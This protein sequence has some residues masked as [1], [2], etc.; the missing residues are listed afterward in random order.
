MV[1]ALPPPPVLLVLVL[2][3]SGVEGLH[4]DCSR[5]SQINLTRTDNKTIYEA[6]TATSDTIPT[7]INTTLYVIPE[8]DFHG[9]TLQTRNEKGQYEV[10]IPTQGKCYSDTKWNELKVTLKIVQQVKG[11]TFQV[12]TGACAESCLWKNDIDNIRSLTV[13]AIGTSW[14]RTTPPNINICQLEKVQNTA[15]IQGFCSDEKYRSRV[16]PST[17]KKNTNVPVIPT[18]TTANRTSGVSSRNAEDSNSWVSV[19]ALVVVEVLVL[20]WV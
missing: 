2:L 17:T 5:Q 12:E 10:Y 1:S 20:S 14:W 13:I 6:P 18:T 7:T 11:V 3:V 15:L 16:L 19:G 8:E 9:V 4:R